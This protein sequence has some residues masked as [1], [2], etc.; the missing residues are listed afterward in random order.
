MLHISYLRYYNIFM[1]NSLVQ[2][3]K[4]FFLDAIQNVAFTR[5]MLK[6]KDMCLKKEYLQK[7]NNYPH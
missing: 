5:I 6:R 3:L 2:V 7:A 1:L 4:Q